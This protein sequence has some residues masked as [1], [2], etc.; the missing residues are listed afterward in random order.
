LHAIDRLLPQPTLHCDLPARGI[1]TLQY[2]TVENRYVHHLLYA[3]PVLKGRVEVIEDIV[4]LQNISASLRLP[5]AASIKRVYLAPSMEDLPYQIRN[6]SEISYTVPYL[7]N[8]Q[9]VVLELA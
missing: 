9:M 6:Q 3:S 1:A 7:D 4:P 2:Q 5:S 8:H